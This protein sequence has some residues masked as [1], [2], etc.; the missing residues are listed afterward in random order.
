MAAAVKSALPDVKMFWCPN[1]R[2]NPVYFREYRLLMYN[3]IL[4]DRLR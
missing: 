1:V 3:E 2:F 4:S